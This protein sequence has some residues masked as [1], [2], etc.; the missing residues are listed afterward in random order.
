MS[1]RKPNLKRLAALADNAARPY[2]SG[3]MDGYLSEETGHTERSRRNLSDRSTTFLA[4]FEEGVAD[5]LRGV[6]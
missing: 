1:E 6:R 3:W 4:G 2:R 5:Y